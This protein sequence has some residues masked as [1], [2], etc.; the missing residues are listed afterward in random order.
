VGISQKLIRLTEIKMESTKAVVK[1]NN[2]KTKTFECNTGV[3]K[4]DGLSTTLFITALHRVI[5]KIDQRGTILNK[6]SQIC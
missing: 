4:G 6:L 3:K 2:R 5:R 1:I